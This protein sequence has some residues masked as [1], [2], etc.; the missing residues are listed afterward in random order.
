MQKSRK[1]SEIRNIG[2]V[3]TRLSGTGG[4]S[5]ETAKWAEVLEEMGYTCFYF[6][7]ELDRPQ[8]RS[9]FSPKAHI[10]P[11]RRLLPSRHQTKGFQGY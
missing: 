7:G 4:V 1:T 3:S 6:A 2:F 11:I 8:D 5:L 10:S 9:V